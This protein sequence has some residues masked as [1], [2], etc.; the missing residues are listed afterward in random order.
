MPAS[1]TK[2]V[3]R[4]KK[5][6]ITQHERAKR[7][8]A[9]K[10]ASD[11]RKTQANR[12]ISELVPER[13]ID[14]G[15]FEQMR[16]D[17][18]MFCK[19]MFPVAFSNPWGEPHLLM[20]KRLQDVLQKGGDFAVALPRGCGKSTLTCAAIIWATLYGHRRYVVAVGANDR[21]AKNL[22]ERIRGMLEGSDRLAE[23]FPEVVIPLRLAT[24]PQKASAMEYNGEPIQMELKKSQL[25]FPSITG[26]DHATGSQIDA[27]AINAAVR[28]LAFHC[29]L[30]DETVRPDVVLVDDPQSDK[31][32]TAPNTVESNL[33]KL[34]GEFGNL[35]GVGK[36]TARLVVGTP[37][38]P[39]DMMAQLLDK[40]SLGASWSPVKVPIIRSFG[41]EPA[42]KLWSEFEQI[43]KAD[44]SEGNGRGNALEFYRE[45][46]EQMDDGFDV[47]YEHYH[48]DEDVS[49]I[50]ACM[51]KRIQNEVTFMSEQQLDP[52]AGQGFHRSHRGHTKEEIKACFTEVPVGI[53]P[54][55][56]TT[57][58]YAGIDVGS[59][60]IWYT[61]LAVN[62]D[63]SCH[64]VDYGCW[65]KQNI[66]RPTAYKASPELE[67]YYQSSDPDALM[68]TGVRDLITAL[69][70]NEYESL[71][72][73]SRRID[74]IGVDIGYCTVPLINMI[75]NYI[76]STGGAIAAT[77]IL[78][79]MGRT[80]TGPKE[81]H[82][83]K[84]DNR[85]GVNNWREKRGVA[86]ILRCNTF[87]DGSNRIHKMMFDANKF[88]SELVSRVKAA[89][90]HEPGVMTIFN[91]Q[92]RD[93]HSLFSEHLTSE[94]PVQ[95]NWGT[96]W[97][98]NNSA[99]QNHWLDT[100][101]IAY[102]L[103]RLHGANPPTI[104]TAADSGTSQAPVAE[105]D[106][107][108]AS[109]RITQTV[110][111]AKATARKRKAVKQF[112]PDDIDE[113]LDRMIEMG[114]RFL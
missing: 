37:I 22:L 39:G 88:K 18:G 23:A 54:Q 41:T 102:T 25:K 21:Q 19:Y 65:P 6:E 27:Y 104:L 96:T 56:P 86:G 7:V 101:V 69:M 20:I 99:A 50:Q 90:T 60:I 5:L 75:C 82:E 83:Y 46:R 91:P 73:E 106:Q 57:G 76:K 53:L 36:K 12:D 44:L 59:K 112:S 40:E 98:V 9:Q 58:L 107:L 78:G 38:A 10:S 51:E 3:I 105:D 95:G 114:R 49:T 80:R 100:T 30:T 85:V 31:T 109:G 77:Q 103:G 4:M 15:L 62:E 17:L 79:T 113:G 66:R 42:M 32:A 81:I 63:S 35:G 43:L 71:D 33:S 67:Q 72:G 55:S 28:G 68:V 89:T 11:A 74:C 70:D 45:N 26:S 110:T 87:G 97:H 93:S 2:D 64:V 47:S 92:D 61:V 108:S 16:G 84:S 14:L 8:S 111:G 52:A 48:T 24:S 13:S 94:R 29:G 1:R 34:T